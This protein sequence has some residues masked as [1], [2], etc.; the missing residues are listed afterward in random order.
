MYD[1]EKLNQLKIIIEKNY[2]HQLKT[3]GSIM[4][5]NQTYQKPKDNLSNQQRY[6]RNHP[7]FMKYLNTKY[8]NSDYQQNYYRT[9]VKIFCNKC[10][11]T[12]SKYQSC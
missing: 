3:Y 8:Y 4:P 6:Y 11:R 10:Q 2:Q 12:H 1:H 5:W 7:E 9:K